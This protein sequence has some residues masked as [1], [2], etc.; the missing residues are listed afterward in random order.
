LTELWFYVPLDTKQ[1]ISET[2]PKP[3]SWLGMEKLNLTQQKHTFTNQK[4]CTTTQNKHKKLEP[5]LVASYD[6]WPGNGEDY[7]GFS[8]S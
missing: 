3:I 2:F 8:T 1:V 7:S 4:K 6:I 5:G